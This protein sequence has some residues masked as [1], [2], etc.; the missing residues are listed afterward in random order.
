MS[1]D[2]EWSG[3]VTWVGYDA[4]VLQPRVSTW[5]PAQREW[6]CNAVATSGYCRNGALDGNDGES[7]LVDIS[8]KVSKIL[9]RA[10]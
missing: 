5:G 6:A 4:G 8:D 10:D 3:R 2:A 7:K 9:G 1:I